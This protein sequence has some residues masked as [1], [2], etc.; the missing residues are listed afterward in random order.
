MGPFQQKAL[1][2]NRI[3]IQQAFWLVAQRRRHYESI[4]NL[5]S[6]L[7]ESLALPV[8]AASFP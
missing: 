3:A 8:T 2:S 7:V 1:E 5:L 6:S 4:S